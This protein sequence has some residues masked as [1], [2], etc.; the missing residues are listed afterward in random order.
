[1]PKTFTDD[2]APALP[3][4]IDG[5]VKVVDANDATSYIKIDPA[6]KQIA[7]AGAAKPTRII[8]LSYVRVYLNT[9]LTTRG[10]GLTA[11]Y[12]TA[13]ADGGI[14]VGS[15]QIPYDMD[16]AQPTKVIIVIAPLNNSLFDG[17]SVRLRLGWTRI[18]PGEVETTGTFDQDWSI[19]ND[20]LTTEPKFLTLD[21]G[22]GHSFDANAFTEGDII[23]VRYSREGAA[24]ADTWGQPLTLIEGATF[25]YTAKAY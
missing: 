15:L 21:N 11:R 8:R 14:Y 2:I 16:L 17:L 9:G 10:N 5:P 20:W 4:S 3:S 25:E 12:I 19:P 7:T 1:M 23:S 24:G 18:T 22:N 6:N 13:N